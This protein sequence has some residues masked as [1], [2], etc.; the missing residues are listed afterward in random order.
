MHTST[1]LLLVIYL[2]QDEQKVDI[3]N[4]RTY[5]LGESSD[6]FNWT[7]SGLSKI[8]FPI[9]LDEL[10]IQIFL[11]FKLTNEELFIRR[12]KDRGHVDVIFS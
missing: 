1:L 5:L 6:L 7:I 3:V 9:G 10:E 12:W 8:Y 4:V 11:Q 2:E